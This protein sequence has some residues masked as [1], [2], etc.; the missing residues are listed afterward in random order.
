M[1][2]SFVLVAYEVIKDK[3]FK[4]ELVPGDY[5]VELK[6][7]DELKM[8]R[9]PIRKAIDML[10]EEGLVGRI[11]NKCT[12]VKSTFQDELVAAYELCEALDGMASYILAEQ[13]AS[14][15]LEDDDLSVLRQLAADMV[16]HLKANNMKKW[17]E[18]DKLFHITLVT[19]SGNEFLT[20]V[21]NGHYSHINEIL[22]FK[23]IQDVDIEESTQMHMDLLSAISRG[24]TASS[25]DLA[26]R[27][28]RR[29]IEVIKSGNRS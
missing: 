23:V 28:R 15:T 7:V 12:F 25:R 13:I 16:R 18:L 10:I 19:L 8:S 24:D 17:A 5:L 14:G 20:R 22:W 21:N 6:L 11:D 1:R 27:H 26:Q 9:T 4:R 3:I 2:P 29:I